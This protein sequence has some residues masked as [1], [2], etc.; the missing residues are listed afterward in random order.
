MS[1]RGEGAAL[2]Q[3]CRLLGTLGRGAVGTVFLAHG[4]VMER[5]VAIKVLRL[6]RRRGGPARA[7]FPAQGHKAHGGGSSGILR[8]PMAG[9]GAPRRSPPLRPGDKI[10]HIPPDRMGTARHGV[11]LPCARK[12]VACLLAHESARPQVGFVYGAAAGPA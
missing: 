5:R 12:G 11:L 8:P 6:P 1:G 9:Y 7:R 4:T 10:S 2:K 3:R